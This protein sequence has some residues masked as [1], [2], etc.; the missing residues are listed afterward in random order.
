MMLKDAVPA[1]ILLKQNVTASP[2]LIWTDFMAA[3]TSTSC[4][5]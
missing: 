3:T 4:W 2:N 1:L 5:V